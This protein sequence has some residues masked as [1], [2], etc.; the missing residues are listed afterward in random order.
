MADAVLPSLDDTFHVR[1]RLGIM[2][3]V[4]SAG[5]ADFT[6]L[7]AHLGATDGNL[8]AHIAVLE[9]A[10]YIKVQKYFAGRKPRTLCKPTAE[11][12]RA[13]KVYLKQLEA[14]IQLASS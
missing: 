1:A 2:T 8:G 10:G 5:E 6:T 14:V 12:R 4:V 7:K 13:F 9:N 11:G 3:L